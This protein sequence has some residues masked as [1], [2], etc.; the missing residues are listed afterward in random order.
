MEFTSIPQTYTDLVIVVSSRMNN[1]ATA[2]YNSIRF[3]GSTSSY[4]SRYLYGDGSSAVSSTGGS[5]YVFTIVNGNTTTSNSFSNYSIYIPNYAGSTNKS[6]S[7]DSA[8]ENNATSAFT[9][10]NAG[11]WSNSSAITSIS[12]AD[13]VL[14]ANFVQYSTAY[15]YGISNA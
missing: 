11:L 13:A 7:I 10:L 2:G 9:F 1:S 8:M 15:L 3:N 12:I 5:G 6:L 14:S 4:S